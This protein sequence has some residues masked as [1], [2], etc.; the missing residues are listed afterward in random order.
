ML[1]TENFKLYCRE[2][3]EHNTG[4]IIFST[5]SRT[6]LSIAEDVWNAA[7]EAVLETLSAVLVMTGAFV[8]DG[9]SDPNHGG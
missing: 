8:G 9:E 5:D 3:R 4:S 2:K 7:E 6:F 1:L